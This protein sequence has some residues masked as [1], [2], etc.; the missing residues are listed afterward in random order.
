MRT[1]THWGRQVPGLSVTDLLA[2]AWNT[3]RPYHADV[4]IAAFMRGEM[5]GY[6]DPQ[7]REAECS[8]RA[9]EGRM[10]EAYALLSNPALCAQIAVELITLIPRLWADPRDDE[11]CA[12]Q[13]RWATEFVEAFSGTW[14]YEELS[15]AIRQAQESRHPDRAALPAPRTGPGRHARIGAH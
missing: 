1:I 13:R 5:G 12:G 4:R 8:L 6:P 3:L 14:V 9:V 15:A 11:V 7:R 2:E 10:Y